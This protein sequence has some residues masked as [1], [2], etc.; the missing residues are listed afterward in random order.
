MKENHF[1]TQYNYNL[2]KWLSGII[3]DTELM[4]EM[5][6]N[7]FNV[8]EKGRIIEGLIKIAIGEK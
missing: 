2:C 1:D 8:A 5:K 3:S 7:I 4:N 6:N